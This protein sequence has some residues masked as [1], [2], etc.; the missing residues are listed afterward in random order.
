LGRSGLGRGRR[1]RG[2]NGVQGG[3]EE[4]VEQVYFDFRCLESTFFLLKEKDTVDY[5]D[6]ISL[7]RTDK[8]FLKKNGSFFAGSIVYIYR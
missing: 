3:G 4:T 1:R 8:I 6:W 5:S 2:K 7:F